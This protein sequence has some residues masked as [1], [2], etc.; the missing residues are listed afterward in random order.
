MLNDTNY[1]FMHKWQPNYW[2]NPEWSGFKNV[3][4]YYYELATLDNPLA[5][6]LQDIKPISS[7]CVDLIIAYM[8]LL[9]E[10]LYIRL[11]M[12]ELAA[13]QL[14][15]SKRILV[16]VDDYDVSRLL[17]PRSEIYTLYERDPQPFLR[18]VHTHPRKWD[19]TVFFLPYMI[20]IFVTLYVVMFVKPLAY[21]FL[22]AKISPR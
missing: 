3:R 7:T 15:A 21:W 18:G 10:E 22:G 12:E 5:A 1:G 19:L 9:H 8:T 17:R 14:P 16:D 11:T 20:A 4:E 6:A 13:G 2:R